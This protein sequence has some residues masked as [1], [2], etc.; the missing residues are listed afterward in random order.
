MAK[1]FTAYGIKVDL[2]FDQSSLKNQFNLDDAQPKVNS[3]VELPPANI[4]EE[5]STI[6]NLSQPTTSSF[7]K[8]TIKRRKGTAEIVSSQE[9]IE[10]LE[11]E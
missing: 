5:S 1:L 2:Q 11:M 6:E 4:L 8:R 9:Y 3:T 10:K 7:V